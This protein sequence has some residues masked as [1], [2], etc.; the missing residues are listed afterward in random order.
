MTSGSPSEA[1]EI[2]ALLGYHEV[3]SGNSLPTFRD[4]ISGPVFKDQE[5]K[6]DRTVRLTRNVGKELPLYAA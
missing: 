1:D 3:C 2:C 5:I 6:G 4:K